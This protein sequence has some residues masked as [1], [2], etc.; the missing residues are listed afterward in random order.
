MNK[1]TLSVITL[2]LLSILMLCW[3]CS[4]KEQYQETNKTLIPLPNEVSWTNDHFSVEGELAL[5]YEDDH[6][7][8][9][10]Q[11]FVATVAKYIKINANK[12]VGPGKGGIIIT[13]SSD[14]PITE[15][16]YRLSVKKKGIVVEAPTPAGI[17]YGLG[18]LAQLLYFNHQ[19]KER[20]AIPT[21]TIDDA[22]RFAWRGLMLDESRHFFGKKKVKE[23][24][25]LMALHKLNKFHWHLT[26]EP[27]WRIAITA[28]PNLTSIG[29]KGSWSD[30]ESPPEFY[31][32]E[33]IRE[34]VSY[35]AAR[36][37]DVIPEIDMPGHASA[38][39]LAYPEFSGGGNAEHPAFTFHPGKEETYAYLSTILRE[40]A[41]LFPAGYIHLGGDEVHFANKQWANDPAVRSLMQ[42]EGLQDLKAVEYYFL[43]RM[44]DTVRALGKKVL[45]W[46]EIATAGLDKNNAAVMWWRHDKPEV[47]KDALSGGYKTV[48]CPRIPMY[49]DFVQHDTHQ[50]GRRWDG[51]G[52]IAKVYGFP[53][54]LQISLESNSNVIGIQSCLW[55]ERVATNERFDFMLWPRLS[56]MSE[57]AWTRKEEKSYK[58]F[59]QRLKSFYQVYDKYGLQYFNV[60]EPEQTPEPTGNEGPA[61]QLNHKKQ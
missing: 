39:N 19:E 16:G 26:D 40:I 59:L 23:L 50:Y 48:L 57:A 5:W 7:E 14:L 8:G 1:K 6:L 52:D 35:A 31:T 44:A 18:T 53:D 30:P 54:S 33:D 13:L 49:F 20:W 41:S 32:Q 12:G 17:H 22:P 9:V 29:S 36:H 3:S 38:A 58:Q 55:T 37:I 11:H 15:E 24:L 34:I 4:V 2:P 61:W 43:K 51:F 27:A 56:A 45:G 10:A 46:D 28:Y 47:L 60:F 21:C 42:R 25:D